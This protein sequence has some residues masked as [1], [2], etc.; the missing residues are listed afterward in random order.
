MTSVD[1]NVGAMVGARGCIYYDAGN[2][3]YVVTVV[4]QG[5]V[6]TAA[7]VGLNCGM[8]QFSSEAKRRA[9]SAIVKF[10]VLT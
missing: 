9:V 7:P 4:W 2:T 10:G 1:T 6:D 8:N 3:Q 5:T